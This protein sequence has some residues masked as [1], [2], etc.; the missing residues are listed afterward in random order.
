MT[1]KYK[2]YDILK[3]L[4]VLGGIVGIIEAIMIFLALADIRVPYVGEFV[5]L[6][7]SLNLILVGIICI[8][9][10]VLTLVCGLRPDD[11]LPFHW[12]MF[13]IFAIWLIIFGALYGGVICLI[14]FLIGLIDDL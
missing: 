7:H 6:R 2:H 8:I 11:P 4:V 9:G 1:K 12:I 14:A 3:I 13:L 5:I 10:A